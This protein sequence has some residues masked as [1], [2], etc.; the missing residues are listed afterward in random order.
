M[1]PRRPRSVERAFWEQVPRC[2]SFTEAAEA[3]GVSSRVLMGWL[4]ESGGVKPQL[5]EPALRLSLEDRCRIEALLAVGLG[6][7]EIGRRLGRSASTI[8]REVRRNRAAHW[9]VGYRAPVAQAKADTRARRP[10]PTKLACQPR[11]GR[12]VQDR[13]EQEHSPKQI[14]RRLPLDFP[15]QA[16]M[17]VSHETIYKSLFVQGRGELRRDLAKRVANRAGAAQAPP[18]G[19]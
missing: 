14:Q 16:E 18:A 2:A 13:L 10:K 4:A 1:R 9:G 19:R 12:E 6:P 7:R 15:D 11:L 3:V 8:S 17:R 5:R